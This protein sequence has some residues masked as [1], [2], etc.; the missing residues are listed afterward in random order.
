M[1][2]E[3]AIVHLVLDEDRSRRLCDGEVDVRPPA[4]AVV[5]ACSDCLRIALRPHLWNG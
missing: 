1:S 2:S 5:R 3:P 4:D